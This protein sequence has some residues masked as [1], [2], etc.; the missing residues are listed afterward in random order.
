MNFESPL[1]FLLLFIIP[2]MIWSSLRR[3]N[4]SHITFSSLH[5][6]NKVRPSLRMRLRFLLV[7]LRVACVVL[8]IIAIARPRKGSSESKVYTEGVAMQL[9]VDCSSSMEEQMSSG[10]R[11]VSRIEVVKGVITEF[12]EGNKDLEGRD[13]DLIGLITFAR[14]ADTICPAV[15]K[16]DALLGFIKMIKTVTVRSEDGTAIGEGLM[17][18]CARLVKA[19]EDLANQ[20]V[21]KSRDSGQQERAAFEIASKVI[22]LLTDGVNN[23][24]DITPEDAA[25]YAK[26]QGIKLYIIGIGSPGQRGFMGLF[27]GAQLNESLLKGM[28]D[29]TG[30]FYSRANNREALREIYEKIDALEKTEVTAIEYALYEE[31][32]A[33]WVSFALSVLMLE[34]ILGCTIFKKIP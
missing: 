7:I 1:A 27:Q 21:E 5:Q 17:L 29:L 24:G 20:Q 12:I 2:F 6:L 19:E 9:V 8:V 30:G 31:N 25:G 33:K 32:Y 18:G 16:H 3:S 4:K 22:V 26:E 14:F 11:A 10:G 28:A 34:M 15:L 23:V 13:H